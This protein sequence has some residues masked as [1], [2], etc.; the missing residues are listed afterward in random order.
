ML[1]GYGFDM[2]AGLSSK[3]RP[4]SSIRVKTFMGTTA[5]CTDISET[6]FSPPCSLTEGIE[7]TLRH[8]FLEDHS[9]DKLFYSE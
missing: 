2:L 8:E 7:R 5:F 9:G 1:V 6:G 4:I 3:K